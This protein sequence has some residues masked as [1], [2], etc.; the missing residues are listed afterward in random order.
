MLHARRATLA[1]FAALALLLGFVTPAQATPITATLSGTVIM[2]AG[3][4]VP[5]GLTGLRAAS[6]VYANGSTTVLASAAVSSDGSFTISGLQPGPHRIR[7][8]AVSGPTIE[9]FH[10][11]T[12]LYEDG[13]PLDL[14]AG[15]NP[16]I[17][18]QLYRGGLISGSL[19]SEDGAEMATGSV[20]VLSAPPAYYRVSTSRDNTW[21]NHSGRYQITKLPPGDYVFR[22]SPHPAGLDWLP[23]YSGNV[24]D[25]SDAVAVTIQFDERLTDVDMVFT[26]TPGITGNFTAVRDPSVNHTLRQDITA[27]PFPGTTAGTTRT[28]SALASGPFRIPGLAPGSYQVCTSLQGWISEDAD[29]RVCF[30][31]DEANPDGVPVVLGE[32]TVGDIDIEMLAL[33]SLE[34]G[35]VKYPMAGQPGGYFMPTAT[36]TRLWRFDTESNRWVVEHE[37]TMRGLGTTTFYDLPAGEYIAEV[38]YF[39]ANDDQYREYWPG[40]VTRFRDA[41]IITLLQGQRLR[42]DDMVVEPSGL[43]RARIAGADRFSGAVALSKS[44]FESGSGPVVFIANGL[45]YPDALA[46]GPAAAA[47]G[48]PL[49]LVTPTAIPAV[50]QSELRRLQ[51]SRIVIVGG[52]AS[53]SSTVQSR[54]RNYVDSSSD[55][56][57][58]AGAD[59]YATSRHVVSTVFGDTTGSIVFVATGANYP[60]ALAAGAAAGYFGGPVV[61]VNG[62]QSSIDSAT[63]SMLDDLEPGAIIIAGGPGAV[64]TS[65]ER[66]LRS[67]YSDEDS[68]V[69]RL[70]GNNRYETA[71]AINQLFTDADSVYLASGEGFA[72]ALA[73]GP[74]AALS[75][76]PLYLTLPNCLPRFVNSDIESLLAREVII[77]GG[78][79]VVQS[80]VQRGALC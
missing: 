71:F 63:R 80:R 56:V 28:I 42:L 48:G 30:G 23:I 59:R 6:V 52:T 24:L 43:Q 4:S 15:A 76:S 51:P 13:E 49:L 47:M 27:R 46:A 36:D 7:F 1:L 32:T 39:D 53:V 74:I 10:D 2:P 57:R 38:R 66:A 33:G 58:L 18:V 12:L 19:K 64:S 9:S 61:L 50:V 34:I 40:G 5:T 20:T 65:L 72:D 26:R 68:P 77:I 37:S 35:F 45:N 16:P 54:L 69:I 79:A 25:E 31:E 41:E 21:S 3:S 60:D 55:V 62:S 8:A 29:E 67:R 44:A 14:V 78:T 70:F 11:G 17:E 75:G 73:G 22:L